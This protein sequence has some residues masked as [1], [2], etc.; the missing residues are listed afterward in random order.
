VI[1]AWIMLGETPTL[2]QAGGA[3]CVMSGLLL[4][5]T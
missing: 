3:A 5:R 4:T 1:V 2:W